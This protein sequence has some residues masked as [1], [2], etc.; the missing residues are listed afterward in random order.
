[1]SEIAKRRVTAQAG[2]DWQPT[3]EQEQ[4]AVFEWVTLM[5]YRLPELRLL[6]H[7]P[8]GGLRSKSEAVRFKR[9]GVKPGVPDL[10][11]PVARSGYHG[12]YIELKRKKGG[13]LSDDQRDWLKALWEQDYYVCVCFGSEEACDTIYAYLTGDMKDGCEKNQ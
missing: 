7:V 8:N 3:E 4:A 11:L 1:M 5:T 9:T 2:L 6:Y 13:K 10:C 12:L